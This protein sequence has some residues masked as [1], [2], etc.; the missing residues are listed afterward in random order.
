VLVTGGAGFVGSHLIQRLLD[1]TDWNVISVD[2]FRGGGEFINLLDACGWSRERVVSITHDL[3]IPFTTAQL[4]FLDE[5]EVDAIVNVA[6]RCHVQESIVGPV[7]FTLNNTQLMINMLHAAY[8]LA[9]DRFIQMSTD[10]VYGPHQP[11]T[12][13]DYQPSSPYAASKAAQ[14]IFAHA[15]RR[16]YELPVTIVNSA[17]MIGER[18][19]AD[20]FLPIVVQLVRD[21]FTVPVHAK[22]DVV[23]SRNYSYVGNVVDELVAELR[24]EHPS[25]RIKLDGQATLS[26]I[27]LV[28]EIGKI[29][30]REPRWTKVDGDQVRPGYDQLYPKL[31][32]EWQPAVPFS[33]ALRR[34]VRWYLDQ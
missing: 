16:T 31:G 9:V 18:Q 15:W 28:E 13:Q 32:G 4:R 24:R 27:E 23:G 1:D 10:E 25:E 5:R 29:V 21:G 14:E 20:A 6:S 22:E 8:G 17:N 33:D 26:N 12:D 2:S 34:T 3:T 30:G 7:D 19:R 11:T